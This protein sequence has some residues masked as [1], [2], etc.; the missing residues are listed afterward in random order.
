MERKNKVMFSLKLYKKYERKKYPEN[1]SYNEHTQDVDVTQESIQYCIT[2]TEYIFN[3]KI[4]TP[5]CKI[6]ES[7]ENV[8]N[9]FLSGNFVNNKKNRD[10]FIFRKNFRQFEILIQKLIKWNKQSDKYPKS[11]TVERKVSYLQTVQ[12]EF[13]N[14]YKKEKR[15]LNDKKFDFPIYKFGNSKKNNNE[16]VNLNSYIQACSIYKTSS[17]TLRQLQEISTKDRTTWSRILKNINFLVL[18]HCEIEKKI[19]YAK[20]E[21]SQNFWQDA[22]L[23]ILNKIEEIQKKKSNRTNVRFDENKHSPESKMH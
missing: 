4:H 7:F 8:N 16:L 17:P 12:S 10:D 18:L 19:N 13:E 14:W 20:K 22:G 21:D 15:R 3:E 23:V 6:V 1:I 5:V 11:K 9:E 2:F